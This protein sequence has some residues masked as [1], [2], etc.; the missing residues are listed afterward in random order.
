MV[1]TDNDDC[2][3]RSTFR[4]QHAQ[5]RLNNVPD[6]KQKLEQKIQR[7][8]TGGRTLQKIR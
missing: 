8:P 2:T 4:A 3:H 5:K 7:Y 1:D 6:S